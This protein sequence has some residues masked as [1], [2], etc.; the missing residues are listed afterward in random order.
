MPA[1]GGAADF[2]EEAQAGEAVG[3]EGDDEGV[4]FDARVED[5][6]ADALADGAGGSRDGSFCSCVVQGR[7][8][9]RVH[10]HCRDLPA[11]LDDCSHVVEGEDDVGGGAHVGNVRIFADL[12][13]PFAREARGHAGLDVARGVADEPGLREVEVV[14]CGGGEDHARGGLAPGVLAG[15]LGDGAVRVEGA[16]VDGGEVDAGFGEEE[17]A[18][19]VVHG[20]DA[21]GGGSAVRYD[22]LV[23]DDDEG[24]AG[25]GEAGEALGDAGK[26][27]DEARVDEV[28]GACGWRGGG[29][30][31]ALDEGVV[32]VEEYGGGHRG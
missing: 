14:V 17:V 10:H 31:V 22:A 23:G 20:F 5:T 25:L 29:Q 32:A 6:D 4:G 21:G 3:G 16:V 27:A 1:V 12:E 8:V 30:R 2:G 15:E 26:E 11:R 18:E 24:V 28:A 7:C 13:A 9:G 19:S